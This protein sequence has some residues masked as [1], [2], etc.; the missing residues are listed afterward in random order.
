MTYREIFGTKHLSTLPTKSGGTVDV[1][2]R[3]ANE[4]LLQYW[5]QVVQPLINNSEEKRADKGWDWPTST[6][7]LSFVAKILKQQPC[8]YTIGMKFNDKFFP[9]ALIFVAENYKYLKSK[10]KDSTFIWFMASAPDE[11]YINN[12]LGD[13]IPKLGFAC[14]DVGVTS[15]FN[16]ANNGLIGL[17]ASPSG[18]ERLLEFYSKHQMYNLDKAENIS[19]ARKNDGRYFYFDEIRALKFSQHHDPLR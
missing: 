10:D 7:T 19:I 9:C 14:L 12:N 4:Q 16:N 11:F 8:C 17:H 15:S 3:K 5:N 2:V 13:Q 18:K 6:K 1:V